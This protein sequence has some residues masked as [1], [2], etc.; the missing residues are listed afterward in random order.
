MNKFKDQYMKN[1]IYILVCIFLLSSCT[2][3]RYLLTDKGQDGNFLI[4]RIKVLAKEGQISK[5]PILVI[6]GYPHRY[7]VELKKEKLNISKNDIKSIEILKSKTATNIYGESGKKGV[8]IITTTNENKMTD[9]MK[10]EENVL[11]LLEGNKISIE[12]MKKIDPKDIKSIEI[13]KSKNEIIKYTA[14]DYQGVILIKLE[15]K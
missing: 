3:N 1:H 15:H 5:T 9:L 10:P 7:E 14:D 11:V 8:M 6:D 4:Q 13:I 12:D 2:S